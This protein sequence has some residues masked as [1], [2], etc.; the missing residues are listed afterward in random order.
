[1]ELAPSFTSTVKEEITHKP[2]SEARL[3]ALLS[4]Y[5]KVNGVLSFANK[6][7]LINVSTEN[8]KIAKFLFLTF[9]KLY[10]ISPRF[11]YTRKMKLEKKVTYHVIIEE[12]TDLILTDLAMGELGGRLVRYPIINDDILGG[13]LA[14]AFLASGS[15]NSPKSSNYHLEISTQ[16]EVYAQYL[17]KVIE[18]YKNTALTPKVIQRRKQYVVYLKK[19]DQIADFLILI[20]ATD[21]TLEF[22]NIRVARDFRNNDNRWQICENANMNKT[23]AASDKQIEEIKIIDR[24][25]GIDHLPNEKMKLLCQLRLANDGASMVELAEKMSETLGLMVSKSNVNHLFRAIHEMA[26]RYEGVGSH[27][28]Q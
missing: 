22:E 11:A 20:G 2:F 17:A 15:V 23:V 3:R 7:T 24:V 18:R 13:Y 25:V 19:S 26:K 8:A 1:M 4:S 28:G 6:Q 16:D 10:G 5:V 9:Q 14:G 12:K 27:D 21:A